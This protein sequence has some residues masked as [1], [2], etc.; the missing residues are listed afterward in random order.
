[1]P[2]K[3]PSNLDAHEIIPNIWLGN[4]RAAAD[5]NFLTDNKITVVFN[6]TKNLPFS[7]VVPIKY[8][9]PVDDNLKRA[10]ID[11]MTLWST[12]ITH[13]LL[14]EY[15]NGHRILVHCMAGM[16]RSAAC[17]AMFLIAHLQW[18][19]EKVISM[20]QRIRP[21][22]FTPGINFWDSIDYFSNHFF[23]TILPAVNKHKMSPRK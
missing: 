9:V 3:Q 19:P 4:S 6:C 13:K 14:Q 12:D 21:I 1:M 16:Q 15:N 23:T 10:E 8:R 18:Q 7:S 17:V 11:N 20:I 22:A 2:R 5:D